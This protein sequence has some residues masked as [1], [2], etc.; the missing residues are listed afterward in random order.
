MRLTDR[1]TSSGSISM[2]LVTASNS[3]TSKRRSPP[4]YFATKD[5]GFPRRSAIC[6]WVRLAFLLSLDQEF[7][8]TLV[9]LGIDGFIRISGQLPAAA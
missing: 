8:Q 3:T 7:A 1:S 9:L 2:A 5:W 4:S 6:V